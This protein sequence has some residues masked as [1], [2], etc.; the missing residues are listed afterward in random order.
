MD[1][2]GGT[3]LSGAY[4]EQQRLDCIVGLDKPD[5]LI[6]RFESFFLAFGQLPS[7]RDGRFNLKVKLRVNETWL[8]PVLP[9]NETLHY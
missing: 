7:G 4:R 3:I 9:R 1:N 6:K 5:L 8:D 2:N